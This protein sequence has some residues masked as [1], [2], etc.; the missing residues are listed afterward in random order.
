MLLG[1]LATSILGN[2][3]AGKGVIKAGKEVIR[4]VKNF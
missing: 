1:I 4:V 2:E 3:L